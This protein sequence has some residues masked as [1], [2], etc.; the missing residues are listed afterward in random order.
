M[1]W[2]SQ[3]NAT[4][5]NFFNELIFLNRNEVLNSNANKMLNILTGTSFFEKYFT[6]ISSFFTK[7][8]SQKLQ[9]L[10]T[11]NKFGTQTSYFDF[12]I[13]ITSLKDSKIDVTCRN[14]KYLN[15]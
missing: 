2:S 12:H 6:N 3:Q 9:I 5:L 7:Q 11:L 14:A 10:Q 4:R 13:L 8:L 15:R 1:N